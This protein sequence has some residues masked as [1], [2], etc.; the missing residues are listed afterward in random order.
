[1][2]SLR[3]LVLKERSKCGQLWTLGIE[4]RLWSRGSSRLIRRVPET[5]GAQNGVISNRKEGRKKNKKSKGEE[6]KMKEK[7]RGERKKKKERFS[8]S[9]WAWSLSF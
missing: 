4:E 7:K 6:K 3:Y 5:E 1:M 8:R 9:E 2:G